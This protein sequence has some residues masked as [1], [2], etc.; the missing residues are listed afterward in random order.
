MFGNTMVI[1]AARG[2]GEMQQQQAGSERRRAQA[3]RCSIR[4]Q[5]AQGAR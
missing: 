2:R 4:Q 5:R 3:T 1:Q